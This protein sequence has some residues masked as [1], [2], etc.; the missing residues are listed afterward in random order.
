MYSDY[1]MNDLYYGFNDF[2]Y[3]NEYNYR[4]A[5]QLNMQNDEIITLNEAIELIR[6]SIKDEKEDELFY[7]R[8][9]E[10]APTEKQKEIIMSI[11]DD[12]R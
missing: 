12:E 9:L 7:S 4:N 6:Q 2:N 8:I 11:R 10:Q 3:R 5:N 1:N